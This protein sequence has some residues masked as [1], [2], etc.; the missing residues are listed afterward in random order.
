M[1][2]ESSEVFDASC[3]IPVGMALLG[4]DTLDIFSYFFDRQFFVLVLKGNGEL[5][6]GI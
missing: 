1:A 4:F 2:V 6:F 3:V 5:S